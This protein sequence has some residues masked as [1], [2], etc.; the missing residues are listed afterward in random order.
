MSEHEYRAILATLQDVHQRL[1]SIVGD[2]TYDA[3]AELRAEALETLST[4]ECE[5][6]NRPER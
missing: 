4:I 6:D 2:L 1:H 3:L 5:F